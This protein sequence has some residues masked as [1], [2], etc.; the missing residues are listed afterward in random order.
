VLVEIK[1]SSQK[2]VTARRLTKQTKITNA[3]GVER[4]R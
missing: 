2:H 4:R 1:C 3:W